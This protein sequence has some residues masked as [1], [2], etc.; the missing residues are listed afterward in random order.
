MWIVYALSSAVFAGLTAVLAKIGMDG[1]PSTLGTALRTLVVAVFAWLLVGLSGSWKMLPEISGKSFLFLI[2]SGGATGISWLCYFKA[3]QL[4]D[5][6]LV[7]PLDKSSTI[8]T[9]LLAFVF[10]G[11][12]P[13]IFSWAGILLMG[14]GTWIMVGQRPAGKKHKTHNQTRAENLTA[15]GNRSWLFY[16]ILSAL[17]AAGT[18]ILAKIGIQNMDADLG[19]A[20]RTLVLLVMAWGIAAFRGE[21]GRLHSLTQR[22]WWFIF[23]SGLA[24]GLSWLCYFRALQAGPASLVVPLDKLSIIFTIAFSCLVLKEKITCRQLWGL[25]GILGGTLLLLL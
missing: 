24:T 20:I 18:S 3:I 8:L 6:H 14:W 1:V 17:F 23:L 25:G 9:I 11:E 21:Q 5:V 22:N 16:G 10:W 19:T 4:G 13:G 12:K 2:L 7:A 15:G